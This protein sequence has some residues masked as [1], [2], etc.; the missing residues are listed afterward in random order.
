MRYRWLMDYHLGLDMKLGKRGRT[1]LGALICAGLMLALGIAYQRSFAE[2]PPSTYTTVT[3]DDLLPKGWDPMDAIHKL[4]VGAIQDDDPRAFDI[5]K[6]IRTI[7]D[8]APSNPLI[9]GKAIRLAGY[10]VPLEEATRQT[11]EF[12]LVPY[13]GACIHAPPPPSNQIVH[14]TLR[15]PVPV[16]QAMDPVYVSGVI[17]SFRGDTYMGV[18]GYDMESYEVAPYTI[19]KQ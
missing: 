18:S 11:K 3:W 9:E 19:P 6:Q 13:M 17:K 2:S 16:L 15:H 5:A 7:L 4:K 8:N 10:V 1:T 14:I 12:L